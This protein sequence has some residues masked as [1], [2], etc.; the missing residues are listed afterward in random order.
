MLEEPCLRGLANCRRP[1]ELLEHLADVI[2][3]SRVIWMNSPYLGTE[4]RIT[5]LFEVI[6]NQ[7]IEVCRQA[8]NLDQLFAGMTRKTME[9]LF[10]SVDVCRKYKNLYDQ[11]SVFSGQTG[12]FLN[13]RFKLQN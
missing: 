9:M 8:V 5:R 6:G 12:N 10:E 1:L 13:Q 7:V 11:V 4:R 2:Q 3:I